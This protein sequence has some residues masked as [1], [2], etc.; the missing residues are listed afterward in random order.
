MQYPAEDET[1]I[2][3]LEQ[4]HDITREKLPHHVDTMP[5][6]VTNSSITM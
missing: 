6:L 4:T 3:F 1:C 5:V 2:K